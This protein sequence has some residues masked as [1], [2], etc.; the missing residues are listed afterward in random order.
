MNTT[1]DT[2]TSLTANS[3][4]ASNTSGTLLVVLGG[5]NI[6]LPNN[7][8]I[9]PGITINGANTTFTLANAGRY[10]ISYKLSATAGVLAQ[11]RVMLNGVAIPASVT[12]PA[13]ATSSYLADFIVTVTAGS[14]IILQMFGV[15]ATVVLSPPGATINIIRLS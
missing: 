3:A 1:G 6:P 14:T 15:V 9:G 11:T 10:Y 12:S 8:D 7:Q 2:G 5:L 4:F 13:V